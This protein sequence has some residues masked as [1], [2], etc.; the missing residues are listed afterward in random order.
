MLRFV[1][2]YA[3]VWPILIHTIYGIRGVD[4]MLYDVAATSGVTGVEDRSSDA[5]R[6]F[7]ASPRASE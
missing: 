2:A 5:P 3:A 1:I 4:R 6:R 7:L